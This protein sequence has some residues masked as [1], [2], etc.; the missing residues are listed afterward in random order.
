[1]KPMRIE[2]TVKNPMSGDP[3]RLIWR[4][5]REDRSPRGWTFWDHEG[6]E[7]F[8]PGNWN[9]LVD[10]VQLTAENYGCTTRIS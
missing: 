6:Y 2:L 5:Q 7:R 1:M 9:M 8:V 4:V 10:R 3:H